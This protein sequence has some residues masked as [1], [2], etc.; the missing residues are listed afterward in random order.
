MFFKRYVYLFNAALYKLNSFITYRRA[1][2]LPLDLRHRAK[3][4]APSLQMSSNSEYW[5][6][7]ELKFKFHAFFLSLQRMLQNHHKL[8]L[9]PYE[10][11]GTRLCIFCQFG[12]FWMHIV[13]FWKD[14]LATFWASFCTSDFLKFSPKKAVIKYGFLYLL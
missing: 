14:E 7:F 13:V 6:C 8:N 5:L 1:V 9:S 10:S 12:Y 2:S 11:R 3:D 4:L